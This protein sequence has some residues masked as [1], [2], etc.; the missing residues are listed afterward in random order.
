MWENPGMRALALV[1]ALVSASVAAADPAQLSLDRATQAAK[2]YA[3]LHAHLA[4]SATKSEELYKWSVR[5]LDAQ[6]DAQPKVAAM[7]FSDHA[8]RMAE[9]EANVKAQHAGGTADDDNV[10]IAAYFRIEADLWAGR[11]KK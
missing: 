9:L 7:A 5:W 1:V 11:G 8:K 10:E 2:I 4:T 3:A 6:L